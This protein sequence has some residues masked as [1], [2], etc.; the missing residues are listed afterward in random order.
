MW[1]EIW[2]LLLIGAVSVP[3]GLWVFRRG[4]LYA[5]LKELTTPASRPDSGAKEYFPPPESQG[6][7]R[8]LDDPDAIRRLAGMDPEK[9]AELR[10]WLR[11]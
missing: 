7:W 4:E 5:K 11:E 10:E 6:G 8:K 2:P 1:G 3:L 9:L